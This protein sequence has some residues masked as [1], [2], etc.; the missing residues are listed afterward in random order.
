MTPMMMRRKSKEALRVKDLSLARKVTGSMIKEYKTI[1]EIR[2]DP[3]AAN[4]LSDKFVHI[5][6]LVL[7]IIESVTSRQKVS[8]G[9]VSP[10]KAQVFAIQQQL[11]QKYGTYVNSR[12]SV[13]V[14]SVDV[15]RDG[16]E[17]VIIISTV[18]CN[19]SGSVGFLSN[20]QR[21]NAALTQAR[22]WLWV[23]GNATTLVKSG[24]I[25]KHL[26]I[27]FFF[28]FLN[29]SQIRRI[30]SVSTLPLHGDSK[31][32]G[33]FYDVNEDK[34]LTQAILGA[35]IDLGQIETLLR[36]DSPLCKAT[37]WKILF[38]ENFSKSMARIMDAKI[39]KEVISLLV[40]L[41]SG[42]PKSEK[43]NKFSNSGG[44]SSELLESY[45]VKHLICC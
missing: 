31:S 41:S 29:P 23:L 16:E 11:G 24:S 37:K 34:S 22:H 42:W 2:K 21:A 13:N 35:T 1:G 36:T 3:G 27:F 19:G 20:H 28:K 15:S 8:V 39:C 7:Q 43:R 5:S 25:W 12:F 14:R 26:V 40:K 9:C 38:S 6:D 30:Y 4:I 45:S 44:D 17:D 33:C 18:R 32:G 10:Y